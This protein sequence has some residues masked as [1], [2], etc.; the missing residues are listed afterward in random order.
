MNKPFAPVAW[1][2]KDCALS[3]TIAPVIVGL[4][5]AVSATLAQTES[6]NDTAQTTK[7]LQF[8]LTGISQER[9]DPDRPTAEEL[10]RALRSRR[11]ANVTI[12]PVGG[13]ATAGNANSLLRPEGTAVVSREG[14]IRHQDGWWLFVPRSNDG[15]PPIKML[16]NAVLEVMVR[17]SD[18]DGAPIRFVVSGETTV[19]RNENYLFVRVVRRVLDPHASNDRAQDASAKPAVD[20]AAESTDRATLVDASAEDVLA[21]MQ[22][23]APLEAVMPQS[24]AV[25]PTLGGGRSLANLLPDGAPLVRR[26]GRLL[27]DGDWW[28]FAFESDNIDFPEWPLRLLPGRTLETIVQSHT[29]DSDG[30]V[31]IV[32]GEITMFDGQNYLLPT[33]AVKRMASGNFQH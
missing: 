15:D 17:G 22:R 11:P 18:T 26:A 8:D 12:A 27:R 29:F 32:S 6:Q 1:K 9:D 33:L 13:S 24:L 14:S 25:V 20:A 10:L 5:I 31:L 3:V 2:P 30:S 4:L 21:A 19:Y 23:Q 28:T 7:L 16:P